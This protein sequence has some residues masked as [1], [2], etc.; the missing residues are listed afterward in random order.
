MLTCH[1]APALTPKAFL[2][3]KS[4]N[5]LWHQDRHTG[6]RDDV[7]PWSSAPSLRSDPPPST[8]VR[9]GAHILEENHTQGEPHGSWRV[10]EP[11]PWKAGILE[12][13]GVWGV[14]LG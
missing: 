4:V 2:V 9:P 11:S 7:S 3:T 14:G 10:V 12:T 8:V 6:P 1:Q 5:T 13:M